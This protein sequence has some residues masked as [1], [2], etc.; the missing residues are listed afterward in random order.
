VDEL[1]G[2]RTPLPSWISPESFDRDHGTTARCR[3]L[4]DLQAE[5][6]GDDL[7]IEVEPWGMTTWW[8]LGQM[9]AAL[10]LRSDQHLVDLACGRGGP[11]LW[12]ARATGATLTGIDWSAVAVDEAAQRVSRFVGDGRARFAVG[13][14]T[15]TGLAGECADGAICADALFFS[16]DRVA[17]VAEVRRIL[18]PGGRFVYTADEVI[19]APTKP[20]EVPDWTPIVEA[21]GLVVDAKV[22]IPH[23]VDQLSRLYAL[24]LKHIDEIRAE[25]GDAAADDLVNE[26]ETVGPSLARRRPLLIVCHRES[27]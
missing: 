24:W 12:L 11:G 23:H 25:V 13:D 14:L 1:P 15:A 3:L 16:A 10:R 6:Y 18:K 9:V 22:D 4:W 8:V 5:A 27:G 17:A 21:G 20:S 26:A 7:P 2:A 19:D